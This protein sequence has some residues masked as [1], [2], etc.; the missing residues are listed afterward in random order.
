MGNILGAATLAPV[1]VGLFAYS[2][3]VARRRR[4]VVFY[5]TIA[6]LSYVT[7][8]ANPV[9]AK[10]LL[11]GTGWA[12]T[13]RRRN[14]GSLVDSRWFG[15]INAGIHQLLVFEGFDKE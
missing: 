13:L 5:K 3:G 12:V 2:L 10:G 15:Q 9:S 4:C 14:V 8:L 11:L 7:P 6:N 1:G